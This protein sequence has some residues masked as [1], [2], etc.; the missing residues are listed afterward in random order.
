MDDNKAREGFSIVPV[1]YLVAQGDKFVANWQLKET[2]WAK[3]ASLKNIMK[4]LFSE[5]LN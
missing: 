2:D 3:L 4:I 5:K 1:T